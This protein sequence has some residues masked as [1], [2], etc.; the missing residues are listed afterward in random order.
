MKP[1][2]IQQIKQLEKKEQLFLNKPENPLMKSA[3]HPMADKI[4]EII[5]DKLASS[6]D[7]IF[8][9]GF[10]LIFEKGS[11][12]I[13]KTYSKEKFEADYDINNYAIEN[14]FNK[15]QLKRIDKPSKQSVLMNSSF[16]ALE[17]G[18]LGI[19]GI[20]LP[21]I[22]LFLSVIIRTL[23]EIALS[24]GFSY[25]SSKEEAYI[26]LLISAAAASGEK[27]KEYDKQ[28]NELGDKIDHSMEFIIEQDIYIKAASKTLSD[29]L[30]TAKFIQGIPVIGAVGGAV[31]Y[32]L[33]N[34]ISNYA[35]MK[36][37]KRYLY[38]KL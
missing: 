21:D 20:G 16:S 34:R 10:L 27:Q 7:T 1:N 9:K 31:N 6:L 22:P 4:Q 11:P 12:Y 30:L 29:A 25:T 5:P 17:G 37:K 38:Q 13:E 23:Y 18:V 2:I 32:A 24:Y 15:R 28:L 36:Y 19:F 8:Y 14:H 33:I 35:R 26:L 3:I